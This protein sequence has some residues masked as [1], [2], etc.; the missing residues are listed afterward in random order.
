MLGKKHASMT[1][2]KKNTTVPYRTVPFRL[3]MDGTGTGWNNNK[4]KKT[5]EIKKIVNPMIFI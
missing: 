4:K 1:C 2:W 3:E 5:L